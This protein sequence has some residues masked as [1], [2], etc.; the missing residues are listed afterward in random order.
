MN[1]LITSLLTGELGATTLLLLFILGILTKRFVP[2]WIHEDVVKKLEEYESVAPGLVDEI[3]ELVDLLS[4][5][6]ISDETKRKRAA[7]ALTD[8]REIFYYDT[9]RRRARQRRT[10][11]RK[12]VRKRKKHDYG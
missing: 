3:S 4:D 12:P 9:R 11:Q 7:G 5:P 10:T 1:E 6:A 8:S 2:W